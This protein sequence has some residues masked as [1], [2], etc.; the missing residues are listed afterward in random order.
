M[1]H[2]KELKKEAVEKHLR[3]RNDRPSGEYQRKKTKNGFLS[4]TQTDARVYLDG[5]PLTTT[6]TD[7]TE[8]KS[9]FSSSAKRLTDAGWN[10]YLFSAK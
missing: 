2:F 1:A 8:Q 4:P 3:S 10:S 6:Q 5:S 9:S 7:I